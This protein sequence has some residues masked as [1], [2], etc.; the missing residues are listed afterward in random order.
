MCPQESCAGEE[1]VSCRLSVSHGE[2]LRSLTIGGNGAVAT[3]E[4]AVIY[5]QVRF[6]M[7]PEAPKDQVEAAL[8]LLRRLGREL[9]VVES[10]CVG[11]DFG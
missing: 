2:S 4:N 8:E 11:R 1:N 9:E 5:H 3:G 6:A 10:F 7:K